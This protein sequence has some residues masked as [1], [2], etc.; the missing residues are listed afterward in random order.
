[1]T[2]RRS[3]RKVLIGAL[4]VFVAIFSFTFLMRWS[5]KGEVEVEAANLANFD[6]G[7]IISDYQ[8]GNYNSMTE[9]EIQAWLTSKNSCQNTDYNLYLNMSASYPSIKWHW[10]DGHFVCISEELFGDGETIGTGDTAAHIIWQAAQD[11]HINPQVLLVLLQKE[12]SL[13]TDSYPN[14]LNYR[15][16]TGYGCP[17]TAACSSTYYGF[18]NQ[19]RWAA[20]LFSEVLN[21]GWTNYPLGNNFIRYGP[22][23]SNGSVVNIRSLATSALYRYTPYQP[24]PGV[25]SVGYDSDSSCS[26]YGNKNFYVFFEDWF[27]G[28]TR[29]QI[30]ITSI[31]EK[32]IPDGIYS[33]LSSGDKTKTIS[34]ANE[35]SDDGA[36]VKT[37]IY[38]G[39]SIQQ[40]KITKTEDY[41][42]IQNVQ[43]GKVLDIRSGAIST[44]TNI[45]QYSSNGSCAQRWKFAENSDGSVIIHNACDLTYVLDLQNGD[46]NIQLY[47]K[48]NYE[49]V[50]QKWILKAN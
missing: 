5:G 15:T 29:E 49:N 33:I 20:A 3:Y 34:V 27:G 50:N 48:T 14:S 41:Y 23:C 11:Y 16:A 4:L 35:S 37:G 21:G 12:N 8:M 31:S 36:N 7:Y 2:R 30:K 42:T 38:R 47:Y 45:W 10:A 25:L 24:S 1:M 46:T 39:A 22:N 6:P 40:W 18:K 26:A 13:I 43:T 17:D 32:T 19:I 28:I 9:A 44:G